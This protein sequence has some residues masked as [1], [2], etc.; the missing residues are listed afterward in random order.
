MSYS[1]VILGT[2]G[3]VSYWKL[4]E[5]SGSIANDSVGTNNGTYSATGVTLGQNALVY[6]GGKSVLFNGSTG[7]ISVNDSTSLHISSNITIE[8]WY[9]GGVPP[10]GYIILNKYPSTSPF[11]GYALGIDSN[12]GLPMMWV[13]DNTSGWVKGTTSVGDNNIHH[14]VG[15]LSGTTVQ[16]YVDGVL[17]TTATRTPSMS[18]TNNLSIGSENG[19]VSWLN[20][21]IDDVAI[22]NVALSGSVISNHYTLGV[23][24]TNLRITGPYTGASGTAVTYTMTPNGTYNGTLTLS[25]GGAG[26]TFSVPSL[27]WSYTNN[28]QTFTYTPVSGNGPVTISGT[29]SPTLTVIGIRFSPDATGYKNTI[30]STTGLLS[31]WKF[32]ETTGTTAKDYAGVNDGTYTGGY[33]LGGGG[34]P[35]STSVAL[36]GTTGYIECGA[37]I[38]PLPTSG[39]YTLEGWVKLAKGLGA[40]SYTLLWYGTTSNNQANLLQLPNNNSQIASIW[41]NNTV[42]WNLPYALNDG[43]WHYIAHTWDGTTRLL[44][45]DGQQV[46]S[47]ASGSATSTGLNATNAT[48]KLGGKDWGNGGWVNGSI[49]EVAVYNTALSAAT[50][51]ANYTASAFNPAI[52]VTQN[53]VEVLASPSP[54]AR[55]TQDGIEVLSSQM[56]SRLTQMGI[57]VGRDATPNI[58]FTQLG[59]EVVRTSNQIKIL[60]RREFGPKIGM[61]Q[62]QGDE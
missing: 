8:A 24:A 59:V 19:T 25:D 21:T 26:G 2:T 61:R 45:L 32:D 56:Y 7:Y 34:V 12:T 50:I 58:L 33:T 1:D 29:A 54:N 6:D 47:I 39:P 40:A 14:I 10:S 22:Y 17:K 5:T 30:L 46:T 16:I 38:T 60:S 3:L 31:Y 36:N 42:I 53:G 41:Y 62:I 49:D 35:P 15:V 9:K 20:G 4:D 57:E 55:I 23:A 37:P 43:V 27:T 44:Y 18:N 52:R 11:P 48:L 51:S 28:A 13:G